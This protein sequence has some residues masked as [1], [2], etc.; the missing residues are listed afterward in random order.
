MRLSRTDPWVLSRVMR[1]VRRHAHLDGR[2][3]CGHARPYDGSSVLVACGAV[4][5]L[6]KV[7]A[8]DADGYRHDHTFAFSTVEL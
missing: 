4:R 7:G 2:T 8:E 6:V 3:S 1:D 5:V